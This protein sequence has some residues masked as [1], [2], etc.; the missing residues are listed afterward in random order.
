[1]IVRKGRREEGANYFGLDCRIFDR[2]GR[3]RERR[4]LGEGGLRHQ[5]RRGRCMGGLASLSTSGV[6]RPIVTYEAY[7]SLGRLPA[8]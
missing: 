2:S 7:G 1:M 4:P 3:G 8:L 5:S 6:K